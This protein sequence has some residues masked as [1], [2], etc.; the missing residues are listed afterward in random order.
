MRRRWIVAGSVAGVIGA[1]LLYNASLFAPA[2][3]GTPRVLAHRGVYQTFSREGLGMNDC[4]ATRI[5]PPTNPYLENTLPS[6]A[7]GF[8]AG[9][10]A[11]EIDIHPT[12]DG[13]FAVFHDWGL[14]C[15][16]NGKGVTRDQSMAYL[17]TLDVGH[18]YTHDGGKTFPFRGKG[19]G[20]MRSLHEVLNAFP[21]RRFLINIKSRDPKEADLLVDYL[22]AHGHP[23]D[24]RLWVWA[25]PKPGER[26]LQIAPQAR[27]TWRERGKD[28]GYGYLAWG[29]AGQVPAACRGGFIMVPTDLRWLLWGWP[30]RFLARMKAANV[31]VIMI[32]PMGKKRGVG[33]E[34]IEDLDAI[35]A[36][37]DGL[38][39]TED[40]VKIGPEVRRR[41]PAR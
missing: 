22:K 14:E 4:S 9:A 30:N 28:C 6:M 27:V 37:F 1:V 3:E 35:P 33:I 5:D 11:L 31:E 13:E 24:S 29:W 8:A 34:D 39:V 16:T 25:S 10:D 38:V 19:V 2:P 15:R 40:V 21:G 7:A 20:M 17:R 36:G 23:I 26:L 41:W 32:A 12:T 18:G